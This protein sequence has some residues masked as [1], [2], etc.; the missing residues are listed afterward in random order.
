[1]KQ[2][3][4]RIYEAYMGDMGDSFAQ[5]VRERIHWMCKE[6][7]GENICDVGCSQGIASILLAR[8]GST[9]LGLDLQPEAIKFAEGLLEGEPLSVK[10][11]I[12]FVVGNF[13]NYEFEND[14][15]DSIILGEVLEHVINPTTF[16]SRANALLKQSGRLIL[17]VPF[18]INEFAD[19]KRTYY[20]MEIVD[21]VEKFFTIQKIKFFGKWLGVVA[22]K[23]KKYKDG[24]IIDKA[25]LYEC[26]N[27]FYLIES[28]LLK[29]V[30]EKARAIELLKEKY[31]QTEARLKAVQ[32]EL[33]LLKSSAGNNVER[34]ADY[35]G[36]YGCWNSP[37]I[38]I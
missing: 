25:L 22:T 35:R 19:H 1:M 13:I 38:N 6:A 31:K 18:G 30:K 36:E 23:E 12:K 29:K 15:F 32:E 24:G 21:E 27:N 26:E 4:D 14:S 17:S 28:D 2:T 7:T 3:L 20:L 10:D 9:V 11:N 37:N 16:L 5:S 8:E 33:N 34:A